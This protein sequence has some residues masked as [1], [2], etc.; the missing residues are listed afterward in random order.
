MGI[1][2]KEV[3]EYIK[4][5]KEQ[6]KKSEINYCEIVR[7]DGLYYANLTW[8]G[9]YIPL[10]EY[11]PYKELR[12]EC[13]EKGYDILPTLSKLKF[14]KYGR[15]YYAHIQAMLPSETMICEPT[16]GAR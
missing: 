5:L 13:K 12:K 11:V 6:G 16:G 9:N 1:N 3:W 10:K 2:V 15:K 7:D 14:E 4:T 8:H